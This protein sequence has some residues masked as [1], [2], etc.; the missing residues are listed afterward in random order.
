MLSWP[1]AGRRRDRA[2]RRERPSTR[3]RIGPEGGHDGK[4][5][6]RFAGGAEAGVWVIADKTDL[7]TK[8]IKTVVTKDEGR[9]LVPEDPLANERG[10]WGVGKDRRLLI[11]QNRKNRTNE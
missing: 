3:Q 7:P 2:F 8:F 11:G 9:Y 5:L 6:P 10:R 4:T 1:W